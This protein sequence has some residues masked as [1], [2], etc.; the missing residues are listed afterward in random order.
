MYQRKAT[1]EE[2]IA[3]GELSI[4]INQWLF[5]CGITFGQ[6][7]L[8]FMVSFF[9]WLTN[10]EK[11]ITVRDTMNTTSIGMIFL[12][13]TVGMKIYRDSLK[14]KLNFLIREINGDNDNEDF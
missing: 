6:A 2:T 12:I 9:A 4:K 13:F 3:I 7:W 8:C 10:D 11:F 5:N 14:D 1:E